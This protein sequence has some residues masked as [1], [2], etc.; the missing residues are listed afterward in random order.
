MK[1]VLDKLAGI[2]VT[3]SG[4]L[5]MSIFAVNVAEI[6]CRSFFNYSLLWVSDFSV[7]CAVW[8]ICLAMSVALYRKEHLVVEFLT[9]SMPQIAKRILSIVL[10]LVTLAFLL[11]IFYTGLKTTATKKELI[12]PSLQW[13]LVWSYS[14]LPVFSLLSTI[15]MIPRLFD[16]FKG[17]VPKK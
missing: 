9:N 12:F 3:I 2:L 7:I 11:M 8:M 17:E 10:S 5:F 16:Y 14:A 15:F 6:I 13:S 1:K 4:L